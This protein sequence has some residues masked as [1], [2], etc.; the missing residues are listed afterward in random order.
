MEVRAGPDYAAVADRH[1]AAN[2]DRRLDR[3]RAALGGRLEGR[4][5]QAEQIPRVQ[6][7]DPCPFRGNRRHGPPLRQGRHGARQVVL[8]ILREALDFVEDSS[9]EGVRPR[10]D[11]VRDDLGRFLRDRDERFAI[12]RDDA[13][14]LGSLALRD[15]DRRSRGGEQILDEA[16]VDHVAPVQHDERILEVPAGLP[17][18][19][20]RSQ[21][22]RL[23]DVGDVT[24]ER[25]P[26]LEVGLDALPTI[27]HDEDEVPHAVLGQSLDDVLQERAVPQRDHDLRDR[28]REGAHPGAL[29]RGEDDGLHARCTCR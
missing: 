24:P 15:E 23:G 4:R 13:V 21:L 26:V 29:S 28:R 25:L 27:A 11:Q 6:R 5:V 8:A 17:D 18:P 2:R 20:R 1:A 12:D 7:V 19:V 3:P 10:V 14:A 22:L 16:P 9:V